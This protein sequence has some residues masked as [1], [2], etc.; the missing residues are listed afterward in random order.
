MRRHTY[1]SHSAGENPLYMALT[2][3]Q[4]KALV[5]VRPLTFGVE[6]LLEA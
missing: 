1:P 4:W 5:P 2:L 6:R 3:G